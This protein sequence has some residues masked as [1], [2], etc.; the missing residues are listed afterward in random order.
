M[1]AGLPVV[2]QDYEAQFVKG[3]RAMDGGSWK[4]AISY[5]RA[6][7]GTRAEESSELVQV[8]GMRTRPYL[9]HYYLGVA[10][11]SSGHCDAAIEEFAVS[12]QQRAIQTAG[13]YKNLVRL[14]A[15]CLGRTPTAVSVVVP[16]AP[17]PLL[18]PTQSA[19]AMKS[20]PDP[21]LKRVNARINGAR[22]LLAQAARNPLLPAAA[23]TP[24]ANL[25]LLLRDVKR[26][27]SA[28]PPE[29]EAF[30][31]RLKLATTTLDNAMK[32]RIPQPAVVPPS[33]LEGASAYFAG[34]Y[35]RAAKTLAD[36]PD[37][38]DRRAAAQARLFRSA[39]RYALYVVGGAKDDSLQQSAL[40]DASDCRKLDPSVF[41]K[42]AVFSPRFVEFFSKA[43]ET[44]RPAS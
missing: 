15:R 6:A 22:Q 44:S 12:E 28:A 24:K 5:F 4:E 25:E 9:P 36:A 10:Y 29:I 39:A 20:V 16:P 30:D 13:E 43:A 7:I 14:R 18:T 42:P 8:Y 33:L 32:Q 1:L 40:Q 2:A 23:A 34:D 19:V 21:L 41:P 27:L 3:V 31:E 17:I 37:S 26:P 11:A 38:P 35:A